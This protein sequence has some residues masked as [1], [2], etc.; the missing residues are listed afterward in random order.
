[1]TENLAYRFTK[2]LGPAD[3][4]ICQRRE[5]FHIEYQTLAF[6]ILVNTDRSIPYTFLEKISVCLESEQL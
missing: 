3:P 2:N 6:P 5:L 4:A 1:M